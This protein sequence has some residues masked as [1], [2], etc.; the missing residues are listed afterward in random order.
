[1]L[2]KPKTL[3]SHARRLR[4]NQ[5]DAERVLWRHLRGRQVNGFKFRRQYPLGPF[6]VDVC[7][8]ERRLVVELDGGQHAQRTDHDARRTAYLNHI[9]YQ[10]LRYWDHDVL[11]DPE[12]VAEDILRAL[13]EAPSP[14]PLLRERKFDIGEGRKNSPRPS[15]SPREREI[16]TGEGRENS[17][18]HPLSPRE[19]EI[20]TGEGRKNSPHP[21]LSPRERKFD[22]GEGRKN[23]P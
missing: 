5:T 12:A 4:R 6:I 10:V 2:K 14:F 18:L 22:I 20:D 11:A 23:S 9:G 16:D 7:C 13:E 1:M 19:R 8:F 15:L 3:T 17:P 21:P